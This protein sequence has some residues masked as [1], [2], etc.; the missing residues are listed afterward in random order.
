MRLA[1]QR[2][3][4]HRF[5]DRAGASAHLGNSPWLRTDIVR[6]A[7][8][9]AL[10]IAINF[11]AWYGASGSTLWSTQTG[12]IVVGILAAAVVAV[13]CIGWL[14]SGLR[15]VSAARAEV[16]RGLAR[17]SLPVIVVPAADELV[18]GPRMTRFHQ[19]G[20]RLV[21]GKKYAVVGT[22]EIVARQLLAC[23][24]CEP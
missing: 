11:V 1:A 17:P 19:N 21:A 10:G 24:V 18:A 9:V 5:A 14:V 8:W 23:G 3:S 22:T 16:V 6:V 2:R 15:S 20:C 12:W 4:R 13:G 7:W